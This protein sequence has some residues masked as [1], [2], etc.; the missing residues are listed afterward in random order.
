MINK[1]ILLLIMITLLF[2]SN[3]RATLPANGTPKAGTYQKKLDTK[4]MGLR[5]SYLLHIPDNY[6]PQQRLPLV[7][8]IHGAF[9]T[10]ERM[11]EQ[12]SFSDLA[13]RENILVAYPAGAYGIFGFLQHWNAGHC[14]GRAARDNTDDVGFLVNV[15]RDISDRFNV[16]TTRV[17]MVGFSNGGMLTYRFA[18][19][20]TDFLAAAAPMAAALGGRASSKT[21]LWK[22]PKPRKP[23]PLIIFHARD[24]PSVPFKGGV[25]PRKGGER[26]Y[27]SVAES[28]D[29][30]VK[31]NRCNPEPEI[32]ILYDG[33]ITRKVW[34]DPL[35]KN[36][37]FLYIIENWGH[38]W[39][40]RYFSDRLDESDPIKGFNA[41][42]LIWDFFKNYSR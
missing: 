29:F 17:Y 31:N 14:C 37:I 13:D 30:W 3:C 15:I 8:V 26:E 38:K 1:I 28:V 18:A 7:L 12:S 6:N 34:T 36:D 27:I 35:G 4:V 22:T 19:E 16:D 41:A 5:R 21:L 40:G 39:P 24:D 20:Q 10:P 23:L 11:E 2:L 42:D 32:E 33:R 25:S 9:S